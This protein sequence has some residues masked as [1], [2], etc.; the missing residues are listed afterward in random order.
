MPDRSYVTP[1]DL[2]DFPLI[3]P[4]RRLVREEIKNWFGNLYD[5]TNTFATYDLLYNAA[6]MAK[7][8][9]GAVLTIELEN[10]FDDVKFI[11]LAPKLEFGSVLVW[12][13]NQIQSDAVEAFIDFLKKYIKG[14]FRDTI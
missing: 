2:T 12:K 9:M 5:N 11:P 10:R 3:M 6:I 13:K 1:D 4:H 7:K 14:I 8:K